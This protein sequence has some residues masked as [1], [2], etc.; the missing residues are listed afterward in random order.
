MSAVEFRNLIGR[1]G[2]IQYTLYGN[3]FLVC[4]EDD[5]KT[6]PENYVTL[7]R[8]DVEPQTLSIVSISDK[9]KE[10]V[11]E[12]LR[13]GKTKLEKLNGQT[14]EQFSLMRKAAN[15]L[16]REIMLDRRGRVRREFE[17]NMTENDPVLI[18]EMFTGRKMNRMTTLMFP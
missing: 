9:E 8:K 1:V 15:I 2:R 16:L 3:V 14:I 13:Q 17:E 6:K 5:N 11:L 7:L 12:C 18:K 4:L 10:Y